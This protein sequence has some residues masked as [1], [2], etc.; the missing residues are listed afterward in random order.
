MTRARSPAM[1]GRS[2]RPMPIHK[3][4]EIY[5]YIDKTTDV[6][7]ID[8]VQFFGDQVVEIAND[9]ADKGIRV[10]CAGLDLDFRGEPFGPMP[11]LLAV[12]EF[13]TKL[14][15]ACTICGCAATRTQRLIDGKPAHWDDPVILV[16]A[17]ESY[18]A[19]CRKHHVVPK[20]GKER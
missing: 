18:Q 20:G 4:E 17:N 19:R 15:A 14:S 13:V 1:T 3:V 11:K 10:I 9:L 8:E 12:A 16:G 5:D 6:V 2:S 7:A